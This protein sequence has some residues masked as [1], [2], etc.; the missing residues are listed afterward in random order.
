MA[1]PAAA[2]ASHMQRR[3]AGIEYARPMPIARPMPAWRALDSA[4]S[5]AEA[6]IEA[7]LET[8]STTPNVML[9]RLSSHGRTQMPQRALGFSSAAAAFLETMATAIQ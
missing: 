7:P 8:P 3:S 4:C 9:S 1:P 6:Q 2:L 5:P